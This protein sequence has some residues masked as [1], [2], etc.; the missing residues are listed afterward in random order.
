[1]AAQNLKLSIVQRIFAVSLYLAVILG[2]CRYFSNGWNFLLD[3]ND[4]Y[5]LLFVS[6]ALL[7]IFGAYITEPFFTKPVDVITN[8]IAIILA[9]L[10][11]N[12]KNNFVGYWYLFYTTA[13]LGALSV[14]LIFLSGLPRIGKLQKVLFEIITKVGQSKL[15]FSAIYVLTIVSYFR[16]EPIEF[17]VFLT[18]W[19]IL[20]TQVAIE[21]L[22]IWISKILAFIF[23]NKGQTQIIGEAI[24]CENPFLYKV[25]VDYF[26]HNVK[27]TKKGELVYL[28]LENSSG[29]I[30]IIINEKQLLNKKWL[31]VYLLEVEG[32]PLKIDLKKQEFTSGSNTIF[33][34]DNAVYA[35]NLEDVEDEASKMIVKENYLY[36]NRDKFIGYISDGSDI[37]KI[38]FHSLIDATN[39]SYKLLK[40]GSVI[41]TQIYKED[42][43]YQIIDGK[44]Y[45]EELEKHNTYGYMTCLAQKLGRYDMSNKELKVVKWLPSIYSPVFFD[46]HE[47]NISIAPL[48]I[49]RLPET[50]LEIL[51]KDT[52]ALVTHNTAILGILGIGKSCLTFELIKKVTDNTSAKI[53]CID[54]TNEYVEELKK[55]IAPTSIYE[56]LSN[57]VLNDIKTNNRDGNTSDPTSWGNE[58]YYRQQLDNEFKSF[59]ENSKYKILVLN[60]DWH[61]V[62]KAGGK[63]NIQHKIDLTVSEKT[64]IISERLFIL[65]KKSW[66]SLSEEERRTPQ[67]RFLLVFE[68]AHSLIPEWNSVANE[69]DQSASNGTAKVVL[70]G[71]KYGLGSFIVTQR[72]ANIS[73]S[74]LNQCN[75]IFALRV[76]DDTGKHFL[77]NYIGSDYSNTLPTLEERHAI[78]VG[79][80]LNLKQP[81]IIR[82]NERAMIQ[83]STQELAELPNS[84]A[85]NGL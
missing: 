25:E 54:I 17:V 52:N 72:T 74:I 16:N 57:T 27:E 39:E 13:S 65:A 78:V 58:E 61:S 12:D 76:F 83:N 3:S 41:K 56:E 66:D 44:T 45:E 77:E 63:F 40:E 2:I 8:S 75:T 24:G 85:T 37:N 31:T 26:K 84:E 64:R 4:S 35:L 82:L 38:R 7:L 68:E 30:G 14:L 9:L 73:K 47:P 33:S 67:A 70:Q 15:I 10:S 60:P 79:K 42:V 46:D 71:R 28:S 62:S 80:A 22:I 20:V 53:V 21:N 11:V 29:A 36:K 5:N 49:G 50:D 51:I 23:N 59:S 81:V 34:K 18:F 32:N 19:I 43:L 69:G 55:Y 6:G 1:M 48:A